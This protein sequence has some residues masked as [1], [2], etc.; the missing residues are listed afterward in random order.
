MKMDKPRTIKAWRKVMLKLKK[1]M[2]KK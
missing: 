2:G 1:E